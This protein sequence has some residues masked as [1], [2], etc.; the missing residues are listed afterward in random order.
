[1]IEKPLVLPN[2]DRNAEYNNAKIDAAREETQCH[3]GQNS[4]RNNNHMI[5]PH[6]NKNDD[7]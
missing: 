7:S 4:S 5:G 2:I 1:M 6:S 3:P